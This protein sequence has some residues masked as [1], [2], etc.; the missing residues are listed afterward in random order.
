MIDRDKS[1]SSA[2]QTRVK[3]GCGPKTARTLRSLWTVLHRDIEYQV[4]SWIARIA[5]V[6]HAVD[7]DNVN[8]LCVEPVARPGR[9][10]PEP[11]AA[12]LEAVIAVVAFADAKAVFAS[13]ISLVSVGG[14]AAAASV[15]FPLLG[16]GLLGVLFL[17]SPFFRLGALFFLSRVFLFRLHGFLRLCLLLF[18]LRR[19]VFVFFLLLVLL[20]L[21]VCRNTDSE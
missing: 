1:A 5:Q 21:C 20:L 10:E 16:L 13:E 11:I 6:V 9:L 2:G 15:C 19:L 8:V 4:H 17:C 14:N 7:F 3:K 12:V 18:F